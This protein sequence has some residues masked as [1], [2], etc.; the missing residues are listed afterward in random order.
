MFP[1]LGS[2]HGLIDKLAA[3]SDLS[4][5][6]NLTSKFLK[7]RV[8][9]FTTDKRYAEFASYSSD[10]RHEWQG[11][12]GDKKMLKYILS[13]IYCTGGLTAR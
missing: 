2:R 4:D 3:M 6:V 11:K 10:Q 9:Y 5:Q 12:Q 8:T 1:L 13:I 7:S